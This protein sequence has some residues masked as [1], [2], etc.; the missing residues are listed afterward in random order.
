MTPTP[1]RG[2]DD[3]GTLS[4][5]VSRPAGPMEVRAVA[6]GALGS[7][8]EYFDFAVYGAF[9]A[10]IF[11]TLFFSELGSTGALL[12]SFATFGV[13]F[14]A[15]PIGAVAFGQLG[16]RFGRRPIL[17]ATLLLMGGSSILIGLLPTGHGFAIAA[18]LV[19]LRFIQGFSLGGETTG[20]QLM[21]MEHGDPSRRGLLGSFINMGSPIS[22]VLAN[23]TLVALSANLTTDQFQAWG[24]RLPFLGSVLIVATAVYIRLKLEETPAFLAQQRAAERGKQAKDNGL[25]VLVTHPRKVAQ[26]TLGWGGPALAFY[27]VAVYGLSYLSKDTGMSSETTFLI[28]MIANGLSVVSC[29]AGGWL[30]DRIGR[31]TVMICGISGSFAGIALFFTVAG[32]GGVIA[33]GLIVALTLCSTQFISGSQPALF[34]EQFPTE[35]RFSG[36]ALS[37]TLAN[38]IFSAPSPFLAAALVA[39]GGTNLVM[40]FTLVV[41][42]ASAIAISRLKDGR[43]VVLSEFTQSR[44]E[45]PKTALHAESARSRILRTGK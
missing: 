20:S 16:D 5:E 37:H 43:H 10:T 12:A 23:L 35:V 14:A 40:A 31:K 34:A 44:A 27:L 7:A 9:A 38:L 8:L 19:G 13:G 39:V 24:W 26:L 36:A 18:I 33:T 21:T 4:R 45:R 1:P 41:L 15:R 29:V 22:Q 25:R 3:S 6:S 30:S 11:P 2:F 17:F 42:V 28:L 32:S